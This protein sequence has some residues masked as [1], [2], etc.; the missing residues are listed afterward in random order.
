MRVFDPVA[1]V[2]EALGIA[3]NYFDVSGR[4]SPEVSRNCLKCIQ[5]QFEKGERRPLMLANRAIE[6]ILRQNTSEG[7]PEPLCD[8]F[9][10]RFS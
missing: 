8:S 7:Q 6:A 9:Y 4:R 3:L 2:Y 1:P 10:P 5:H